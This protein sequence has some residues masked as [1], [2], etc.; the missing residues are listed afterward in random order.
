MGERV[1]SGTG[2]VGN[3]SGSMINTQFVF[4]S[5]LYKPDNFFSGKAVSCATVPGLIHEVLTDAL[6]KTKPGQIIQTIY[7]NDVSKKVNDDGT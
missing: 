1:F 4:S 6:R 2:S 5:I 3:R 7:I